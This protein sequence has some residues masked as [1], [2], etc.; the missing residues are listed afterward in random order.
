MFSQFRKL[1]RFGLQIGAIWTLFGTPQGIIWRLG[2]NIGNSLQKGSEKE[3]P[4]VE[5]ISGNKFPPPAVRSGRSREEDNRRRKEISDAWLTPRGR[6][7]LGSM[8]FPE[9]VATGV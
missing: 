9:A 8:R 1:Y 7:I 3:P 5:K 4:G 6:R 2:G